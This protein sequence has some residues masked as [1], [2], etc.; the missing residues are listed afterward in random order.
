MS[1]AC[2]THTDDK[3]LDSSILTDVV[4]QS[5][6][7]MLQNTAAGANVGEHKGGSVVGVCSLWWCMYVLPVNTFDSF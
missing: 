4:S 1:T 6:R 7:K 2:C 3:E 5:V